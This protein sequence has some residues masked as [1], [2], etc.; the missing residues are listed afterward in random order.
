MTVYIGKP[1]APP[2]KKI[3]GRENEREREREFC[4]ELFNLGFLD[5]SFKSAQS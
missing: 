3:M 1:T 2:Q 5:Y 4:L